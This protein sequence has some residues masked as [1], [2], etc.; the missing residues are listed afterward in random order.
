MSMSLPQSKYYNLKEHSKLDKTTSQPDSTNMQ[1]NPI[2]ID[3][4]IDTTPINNEPKDIKFW[5]DDPNMLL[6]QEYIFELFPVKT[7]T[8]EQKLNAISRT[9]IIISII[10]FLLTKN[11]RILVI[12]AIT[13]FAIFIL[14]YYHEPNKT[15]QI[16]DKKSEGFDDAG[17]SYL[18]QNNIII[19]DDTFTKPT[20]IN[21]FNNV[22]LTDYDYNPN[23][24]P[25]PAAYIDSTSND[26]LIKAKQLVVESNPDQ[27]DI[28][29]KLFTDLGDNLK[30]E[31]SLRPFNSNPSTTIPN[32]QSAFA[33]FCYG[34]M[35]SCKEGNLF[36]CARNLA[37]HI[38]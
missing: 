14:Y 10:S 9:I 5:S 32:D 29:D 3:T 37:R 15:Q 1:L 13:L 23:K 4:S 19:S 30:F 16:K 21:P 36:A 25:A 27:P 7:M 18:N 11:I 33:D 26:I 8:Y 6:K 22:M 2:P 34:S 24:K 35:V 20:S 12:L 17:I 28:A 38:N 31:Q